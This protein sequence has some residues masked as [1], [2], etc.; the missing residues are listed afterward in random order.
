[1]NRVFIF[2]VTLSLVLLAGPAFARGGG[3][4]CPGNSCN[5]PP[6]QGG[7]G[8]DSFVS[9]GGDREFQIIKDGDNN[10]SVGGDRIDVKAAAAQ[11]LAVAGA[12]CSGA[13]AGVSTVAAGGSFSLTSADCRLLYVAAIYLQTNNEIYVKKGFKIFERVVERSLRHDWWF[14][15]YILDKVNPFKLLFD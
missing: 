8:G 5:A 1:M 9:I 6:G 7:D 3:N 2:I 10:F 13:S 12:Y 15:K 14:K 4:N 11:A